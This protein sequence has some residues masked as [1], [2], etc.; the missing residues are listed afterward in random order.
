MKSLILAC[1]FYEGIT[2]DLIKR[3]EVYK[4]FKKREQQTRI[5]KNE[6]N[7]ESYLAS[8]KNRSNANASAESKKESLDFNNK[9]IISDFDEFYY[10]D[11][12][13]EILHKINKEKLE[14]S[15]E[16]YNNINLNN[17]LKESSRRSLRNHNNISTN[18]TVK[19]INEKDTNQMVKTFFINQ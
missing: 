8:N 5:E 19:N 3:R 17:S 9:K 4:H 15:Q 1:I 11:E 13:F 2:V 10:D 16:N 7:I 18:N 12:Q 6:N 14:K